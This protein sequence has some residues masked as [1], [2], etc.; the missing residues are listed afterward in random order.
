MTFYRTFSCIKLLYYFIV[1]LNM[2]TVFSCQVASFKCWTLLLPVTRSCCCIFK[3]LFFFKCSPSI[4]FKNLMNIKYSQNPNYKLFKEFPNQTCFESFVLLSQY[5][6]QGCILPHK[7]TPFPCGT[8]S[9][10]SIS[11][12]CCNNLLLSS[13]LFK[14]KHNESNSSCQINWLIDSHFQSSSTLS[15]N[16][17]IGPSK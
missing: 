17:F 6:L 8:E 2:L 4:Q 1:D 10:A 16:H 5:W 14:R 11:L 3:V 9:T 7:R 12:V 13:K 15:V